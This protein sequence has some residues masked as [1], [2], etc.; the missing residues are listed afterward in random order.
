MQD[1]TELKLCADFNWCA[2]NN[3]T[4]NY[5]PIFMKDDVL[6][7]IVLEEQPFLLEK[8]DDSARSWN[9]DLVWRMF[10]YNVACLR[11]VNYCDGCSADLQLQ[12]TARKWHRTSGFDYSSHRQPS[13]LSSY[14]LLRA[15]LGPEEVERVLFLILHNLMHWREKMHTTK[16]FNIHTRKYLEN[17]SEITYE[18]II[19]SYFHIHEYSVWK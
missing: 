10:D 14:Y 2:N 17:N 8:G 15:R 11:D 16:K 1:W 9:S 12:S 6:E 18:Y 4:F 7:L 13:E 5:V 19:R 3:N